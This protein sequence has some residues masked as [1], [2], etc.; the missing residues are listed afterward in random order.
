MLVDKLNKAGANLEGIAGIIKK[1]S[2]DF[3]FS[4]DNFKILVESQN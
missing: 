4:N 2:V 1:D 3:Q